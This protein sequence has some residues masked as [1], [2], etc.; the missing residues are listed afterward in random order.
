MDS[1]DEPTVPGRPFYYLLL[2]VWAV[3]GFIFW[4]PLVARVTAV[5]AAFLVYNMIVDPRRSRL[6]HIMPHLGMAISFYSLGFRV[7]KSTFS[8]PKTPAD[9]EPGSY[10]LQIGFTKVLME[11]AT[12][13]LFWGSIGLL[14][15]RIFVH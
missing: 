7:L 8:D 5:F 9:E 1:S 10:P 15:D 3:V 2:G 11:L 12:T 6:K 4:I 13:F 14:L